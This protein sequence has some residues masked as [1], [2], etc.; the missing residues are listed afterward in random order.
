MIRK[1]IKT[2]LLFTVALFIV[3]GNNYFN[4]LGNILSDQRVGIF[5]PDFAS[6]NGIFI[7][8]KAQIHWQNE[9]QVEEFA[10]MNFIDIAIEKIVIKK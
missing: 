7:S 9:H 10:G 4:T 2:L 8:G 1:S 3:S 5:I 6:L